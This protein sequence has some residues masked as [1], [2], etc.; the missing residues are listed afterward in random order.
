MVR[1]IKTCGEIVAT[2]KKCEVLSVG[3]EL[4]MGQVANTD[5]QYISARLPELGIG[6]YYHSVVG[7]NPG[8]V[9]E[10][11]RAALKR[12]DIVITTGGLGPTQD[13]LTKNVAAELLGRKTVMDPESRER[14]ENYFKKTGRPMTDSNLRQ[15]FFPEGAVIL[16]NDCGTAP[17]CLIETENDGETKVI[18][19]L[20]GPPGE[21]VPMFENEVLPRLSKYS[22][23][24]VILSNYYPITGVPESKVESMLLD[25]IEGRSNPTA[26]TYVK[27][28]IVTVR[29]TASGGDRDEVKAMADAAG[30]KIRERFGDDLLSDSGEDLKTVLQ[31]LCVARGIRI[32]AAESLTGGLIPFLITSVPGASAVLSGSFVTYGNEAKMKLCGVKK[33]TLDVFGAVSRETCLEM[34]E[35]TRRAFSTELVLAT[36]GNAGPGVMENKPAG[37]VYVGAMLYDKVEICECRFGGGRENVRMRSA[38]KALD[39]ARRMILRHFRE[40]GD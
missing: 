5:A 6:V 29:V 9:R 25:L 35:G 22:G 26:A 1:L 14:I 11:L 3:T 7:D 23:S 10:A 4:L 13:D 28:G 20:P 27:D 39:M 15:A 24:G 31:K 34:L 40:A 18:I 19:M 2:M 36:T 37:L 17:G 30:A 32:S 21:L 16:K 12:S 33:E 8:R 38:V